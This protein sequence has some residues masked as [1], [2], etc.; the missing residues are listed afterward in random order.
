[1]KSGGIHPVIHAA[2]ISYGFV[3]LHPFE[4]G[5]GR[6]HRFLIHNILS[7][8]NLIPHNLIFPVSATMLKHNSQYNESLEHFSKPISNVTDYS[9]DEFGV[10]EV[11]NDTSQW[12]KYMDLTYQAESLYDFIKLTIEEELHNEL[13]FLTNYDKTKKSLQDIADLP[14][15][16]IDLFI[17]FCLQNRGKLSASKRKSFFNFLTD[18]ELIRMEQIVQTNFKPDSSS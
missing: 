16:Y 11:L 15:R 3:F 2:I 7:E 8:Y 9:L 13:N 1:M 4:D 10:M 12:Y 5:N 17:K 14:D 18:D 6:I